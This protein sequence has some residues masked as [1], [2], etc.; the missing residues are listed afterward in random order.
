[1]LK[2][3]FILFTI[4]MVVI[5]CSST[6][7]SNGSGTND[8]FNRTELL[9]N[10]ADNLIVPAFQDLQTK[11]SALDVA[12]E[13]F[14]TNKSVTNLELLSDAWLDAYKVW[15]HVQIYNLGEADNLGGGER[16]FVSFFNI[17]P[18]TVADIE[19]GANTGN[20]DLNTANYHDAQG[21]P[22]LDFLIHGVATGD[23]LPIDKF[24]T[25]SD[26]NGYTTYLTDVITQM[27]TLNDAIV[28]SWESGY[29]D[30]FI[31]NTDSGVNGSFN[32]LAND[33]IY[34]YEKDFR[35]QKVGIPAGVF[36]NGGSLPE[37]VEAFYKKDVSKELALEALIGIENLFNG[38]GYASTTTGSSL[39]TYLEFLDRAD[40]VIEINNQFTAAEN[41]INGLNENFY[42]QTI[43]NNAQMTAAY[44]II[45]AAIPK[46]KV[47]MKQALNF[48][49]DYVDGD[50]D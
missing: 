8:G 21:F 23:A 22:A 40:L 29:R 43:D 15:Q 47:D 28:N 32:K 20:Y 45:Q 36:S 38:V 18:V 39:N 13:S 25:N 19:N 27:I 7:D 26:S 48:V 17:Y 3:V 46:L 35:A 4:A 9:T 31:D 50:G 34:S 16:G 49:I 5:A 24:I 10:V 44:D 11:L 30:T 37:T 41:A 33:L 6:D 12:N 42:Q 2:K 1:M 14:V